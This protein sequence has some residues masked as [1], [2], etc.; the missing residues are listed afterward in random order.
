MAE[1]VGRLRNGTVQAIAGAL[2]AGAPVGSGDAD[3]SAAAVGMADPRGG[4]LG[5][6]SRGRATSAR[7]DTAINAKTTSGIRERGSIGTGG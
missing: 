5:P 1:D 7:A 4:V 6:R 2:E 3:T